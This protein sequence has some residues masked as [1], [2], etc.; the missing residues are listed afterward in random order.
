MENKEEILMGSGELYMHEFDG[1]EIPEDSEIETDEYNVGHCNS[2]FSIEYTPEL[3]GVK[4]QYGKIVKR[5][6]IS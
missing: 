5:F 1:T 6:T 4:N 2:G 3:Y